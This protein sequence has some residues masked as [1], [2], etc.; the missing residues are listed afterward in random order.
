MSLPTPAEQAA[1]QM[2]RSYLSNDVEAPQPPTRSAEDADKE[3]SLD[4]ETPAVPHLSHQSHTDGYYNEYKHADQPDEDIQEGV[5]EIEALTLTWTR[6]SL[7]IAYIFMFLMYLVRAFEGSIT[8]NLGP[9]IVSGFS[10]HSLIPIIS[11]VASIMGAVTYLTVA[12]AVNVWGRLKGLVVLVGLATI[13]MILSATCNNIAT[14]C[15]A[16]IFYSIGF[17]GMIFCIDIITADTSSLKDRGLAYAFTSSPY[18]ITAFAGSKASEGFYESN[19]RWAYGAFSIILPAVAAPLV[20]ILFINKLQAK[21][22]GLLPPRKASGRTALQSVWYY[23]VQFDIFGIFLIAG[24]LALF[25]LPFSIVETFA[26]SWKSPGIIAMIIIGGLML[27]SFAFYERYLAPEPFVP[28]NLLVSK[29]V[30]G[31]CLLD[32]FFIIAAGCWQSY[33]TSYLQVVYDVSISVA[34]YIDS[35]SSVVNGVWLI[36]VGILIRKTGYYKWLMWPSILIYILFTGLLIYFRNPNQSVGFNVMCQIFLA[37]AGGALVICMQVSVL[38][39]GNHN[40]SAALLA[41]LSTFGNVGSAVGGSISGAIWTHTLPDALASRLPAETIDLL[42]DIYESLDIQLSYPIGDPTRTA[43]IDAYGV[44]QK[45]M[46]IAGTTIMVIT[47]ACVA[48]IKNIKVS[49]VKQVKGMLF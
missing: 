4:N 36:G 38:A 9:Y 29:T 33:Y 46:L 22:N 28:W 24:G 44:G 23:A 12:R 37:L 2:E 14:Y 35:A 17:A 3:K 6:K 25:L 15:A 31:T 10:A 48:V 11:V 8:S 41:I 32:F 16:Q 18:V 40:D 20:I 1:A 19:W 5:R 47:L 49:E 34:G 30:L 39:A 45:R 43:I 42:D 26:D 27:I 21:K 7:V 13:G